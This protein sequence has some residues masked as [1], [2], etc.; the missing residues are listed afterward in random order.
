M[1]G[2][3]ESGRAN[4]AGSQAARAQ[5]VV[6]L[7]VAL[8]SLGLYVPTVAPDLTWANHGADG[9]DLI[10]AAWT[11][12]VPHPTGHPVYMLMTRVWAMLPLGNV[13][14]RLNL[15]SAL[16]ATGCLVVSAAGVLYLLRAEK[17]GL[18]LGVAAGVS[19][20]MAAGRTLWSQAVI[21]EVYTLAAFWA[22]LC[23]Y[24]ALR[25]DLAARPGHWLVL[26]AIFGLGMGSH[27]TVMLTAPALLVL[28]W[29]RLSTRR[30]GLA[31]TG[32]AVGL[33]PFAYLPLASRGDPPVNWGTPHTWEGFWWLVSGSL[34]H[35][36]AF[37]LPLNELSGRLSAWAALWS[38]QWGWHGLF[39][40]LAGWQLLWVTHRRF[41]GALLVLYATL[42][43]YALGYHTPDS[44]VYLIPTYLFMG[45]PMAW[46]AVA[47]WRVCGRVE[48]WR[49]AARAG[50]IVVLLAVPIWS[51]VSNRAEVDASGSDSA[52]LWL[53]KV[54]EQAPPG[55]LVV[56]GDDRHTFA[57]A[58]LQWVEGRR[59]DL[60]V[61]DGDLWPYRWYAD[62]ARSRRP[63]LRALPEG[64]SLNDL[65]TYATERWSVVLTTPRDS[66]PAEPLGTLWLVCP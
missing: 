57:L 63:S 45:V 20:A 22:T 19:L 48:R 8:A 39:L 59:R 37:S 16:M 15:F 62:Q 34:Y 40:V 1:D 44:F 61:V 46:G 49:T 36:Y 38:T 42:T 31:A 51:V 32:L 28:L 58:Y 53:E 35:G 2:Q 3:R 52:R 11:G 27:L 6:L 4:A 9:G 12:G 25:D 64:A 43:A 33:L 41:A 10:A 17:P 7:G 55:A 54:V 18:R 29:P 66:I 21:A 65:V 47:L 13:A 23:L 24:L 50:A 56:S 14:Y 5:R 26:G 60:L 30:V